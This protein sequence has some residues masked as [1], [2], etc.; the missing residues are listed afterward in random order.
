MKHS[1]LQRGFLGCHFQNCGVFYV[2]ELQLVII[3][4]TG[5]NELCIHVS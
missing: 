1:T 2:V 3:S 5:G 4:I